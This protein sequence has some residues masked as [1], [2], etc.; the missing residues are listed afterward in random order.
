MKT[1][2]LL[3]IILTAIVMACTHEK[4]DQPFIAGATLTQGYQ[5]V[6][7]VPY[8]STVINKSIIEGA[9]IYTDSAGAIKHYL[10]IA[11]FGNGT[12]LQAAITAGYVRV[13]NPYLDTLYVGNHQYFWENNI[14]GVKCNNTITATDSVIAP[15]IRATTGFV[16]AITGAVTGTASNSSALLTRD[17]VTGHY[18]H[19]ATWYQVYGYAAPIASPTFT[20]QITTPIATI[21]S[22][23]TTSATAAVGTIFMRIASGDTSMWVLIRKTGTI[24]ARWKKLSN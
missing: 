17:T 11:P 9:Q 23:D 1:K 2:V 22:T 19:I 6:Y 13:W 10:C 12:T 24:H 20:T 18:Y 7:Y 21:T 4:A 16:G 3:T 15:V 8:K 14:N 5:G